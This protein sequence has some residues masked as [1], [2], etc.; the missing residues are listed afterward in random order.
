MLEHAYYSVISPEG[1]ASILWKDAAKNA[2]AAESLRIHAEDLLEF[3][4][5]HAI[6]PEAEGGAHL[7][8]NVTFAAVKTFILQQ[9]DQLSQ[10]S[11]A[12]LLENRYQNV[13]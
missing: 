12:E 13:G 11:A 4:I 2:E 10:Q 6:L 8:P 3:G 5:I 7:N 1:C 9:I